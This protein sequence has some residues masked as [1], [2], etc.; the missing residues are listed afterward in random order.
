MRK[1]RGLSS[2]RREQQ[3]EEKQ[4]E[5]IALFR[6]GLI[7]TLV[8]RKLLKGE[9]AELL[10]K[11]SSQ[12]H[13]NPFNEKQTISIRTL[14]RYIKVYQDEGFEGL[15]PKRKGGYA[16]RSISE[17]LIK[18]A[19]Q[20]KQER[21]ERSVF[22]IIRMLE[23]ANLVEPNTISES[24]LSKQLRK[25]GI[26]RQGLKKQTSRQFRRYEFSYRNAC[27]Q[28]DVQH[29]LYLPHPSIEGKRVTAKLF[30]FID[31]Y[32]RLIVS[33]EFYLEERGPQ[34]ED[35]LQKAILR[36]GKPEKIYVDNGAIYRAKVLDL[37]CA[38][39][40]ID[41]VHS[42]AGR[43]EGR[44]KIE[45]FFRFVDTSFK[46]E[47]Y[48]LIESGKIKT[49]E[50]L[51]QYFQIWLDMMYHDRKHGETRRTPKDR[52]E[53]CEQA[54][55]FPTIDDV[56]NAF[57]WQ[58]ERKVDKT[59]CISL[60]T[61]R[62]EVEQTLVGKTITLRYDPFDLEIIEVWYEGERYNDALVA[63]LN[64]NYDQRVEQ[65]ETS[66]EQ[67]GLNF[68][69]LAKDPHEEQK[70]QQRGKLSYTTLMRSEKS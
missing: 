26:T 63:T 69:G 52:F 45:R 23:L 9:K 27:W 34:L 11:I 33:G 38:Y 58:E 8:S 2:R 65:S 21:P 43:P 10:K 37:A 61:N 51:N 41:L 7:S 1:S 55:L 68:L 15:K 39:L 5:Q 14:E 17:D 57:K 19:I 31:D 29:T 42:K 46:P 12:E 62:Y 60:Q 59:G 44:G 36:Y 48:D 40:G 16:A 13:I 32:S 49:V 25:R 66:Q 18:K 47:A 64:S 35:C 50:E 28:G 22:Q 54:L 4:R 30:A 6:Y 70:R 56:K 53:E 3:V 67:S 24:T 20:L